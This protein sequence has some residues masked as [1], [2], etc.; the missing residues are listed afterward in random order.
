MRFK[1]QFT[2]LS[3]FFHLT[4]EQEGCFGQFRGCLVKFIV[5]F[6]GKT[7]SEVTGTRQNA[8]SEG[9]WGKQGQVG[10]FVKLYNK[11]FDCNN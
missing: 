4:V 11:L 1:E 3:L 5:A 10:T 2:W 8:S 6:E 7:Y 9:V